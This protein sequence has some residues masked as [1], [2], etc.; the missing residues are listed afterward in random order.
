MTAPRHW[1][2]IAL[3]PVIFAV[4]IVS[5]VLIVRSCEKRLFPRATVAHDSAHFSELAAR[6]KRAHWRL[7]GSP[8]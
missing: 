4:S 2:L 5:F 3:M 7:Y 6:G 8:R 1:R